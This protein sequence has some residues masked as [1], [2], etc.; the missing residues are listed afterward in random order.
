MLF[1]WYNNYRKKESGTNRRKRYTMFTYIVEIAVPG[2]KFWTLEKIRAN[3]KE[4]AKA[5]L[6]KAYG[7]DAFFG[8]I[9]EGY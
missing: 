8:H 7:E 9:K 1:L 3:S 2:D 6:I 4:E 5:E